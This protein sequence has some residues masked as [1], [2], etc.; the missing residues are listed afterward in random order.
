MS[1]SLQCHI[2]TADICVCNK[3]TPRPTRDESQRTYFE[4]MSV[5]KVSHPSSR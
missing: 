1:L 5:K 4:N 2:S 3:Q